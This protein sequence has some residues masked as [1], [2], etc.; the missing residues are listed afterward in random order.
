MH[1]KH[2]DPLGLAILM[3][4]LKTV[5]NTNIIPHIWKLANIVPIP[6]PNKDIDKGTSYKPISLFSVI[7]QTLE[8]SLLPCI[9]ANIPNTPT[10]HGYKA[11]QS[12]V[13]ALHALNN[14]V[15][16]VFNQ[17][18]P[19]VR[20]ITVALD[21]SNAFDT[22]NIHTLIRK[23]LQTKI[24][25]TIIKFIANYIKGRKAYT[26][27]INPT[28]S[29][30][31]FKTG[32]PQGGALSP[33]LFNIYTAVIPLPRA[34]IQVMAYADDITI[35]STQKSTSA[36]KKYIQ[37]YLHKDFAWAQHNNLT[38]NPDKTTCT[39]LTPDPAE[40]KSNLDLKINNTALPM[41]MHSKVLG[42]T[43]DSKLTYN[44]HIHIISVQ[45]YK[46]LQMIKA[47]TATEWGKQKETPM[48][49]YKAVM[50]PALE[51]ASS[52]WSPLAS[53]TSINKL[54]I[55]QNAAFRNA[56]GCTQDTNIHH[57]HDETLI[58]PIHEHLQLNASQSK[59]NTQHPSHPYTN[60]QHTLTLQG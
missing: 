39:L 42:L 1:L 6:K 50:R 37:P 3:S 16:K 43:L 22:I 11:Q 60:I 55:M 49:T 54:Q 48:I 26:T 30:R 4:M 51:Y 35:T 13:T 5:L 28:P 15:A 44:S 31:L 40:Y 52:I 53:S 47:L 57:L 12:T 29:Q 23:L 41:A 10:Q 20:A 27:Y 34:P 32:V 18:A 9:I 25:D 36:A 24:P 14:T 19:A 33:P 56:T 45:A 58:L 21:M 59:Q 7:A 38:L 8:K 17:I 46:P 2:I